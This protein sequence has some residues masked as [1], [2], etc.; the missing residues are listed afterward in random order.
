[1]AII[2]T[3]I[4]NK[5]FEHFDSP[6]FEVNGRKYTIIET[7]TTGRGYYNTVD[8]VKNDKGEYKEFTRKELLE[9]IKKYTNQ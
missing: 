4:N 9:Y 7:R 8:I 6:C 3:T 5:S 1:M 2:K